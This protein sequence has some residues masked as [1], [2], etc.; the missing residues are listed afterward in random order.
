MDL[1]QKLLSPL[2]LGPDRFVGFRTDASEPETECRR[3]SRWLVANG[4]ID[5][6]ILGLGYNGHVAMNEPSSAGIP[7]AHVAKLA[8]ISRNHAMLKGLARKPTYGLTLGLGEILQS[9]KILLLVSGKQKRTALRRLM[10]PE[11]TPR[12]PASFL[13][14][15]PDATVFCDR[16]AADKL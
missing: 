3:I 6:C 5:I 10:T 7:R 8:L 14:L 9:R 12:F 11:V 1:R 16:E 2:R 13:W 15:H 4:P